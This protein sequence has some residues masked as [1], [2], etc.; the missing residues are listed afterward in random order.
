MNIVE[1]ELKEIQQFDQLI[2]RVI[3]NSFTNFSN[4]ISL[5]KNIKS[6]NRS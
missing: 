2:K 5:Y 1:P 6:N 3:K 4:I